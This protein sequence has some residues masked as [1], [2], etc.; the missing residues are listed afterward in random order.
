MFLSCDYQMV[1]YKKAM[2]TLALI[3]DLNF[4]LQVSSGQF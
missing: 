2:H 1:I 3:Y 4:N